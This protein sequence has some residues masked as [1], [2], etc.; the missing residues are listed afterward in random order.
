LFVVVHVLFHNSTHSKIK[1][2]KKK[3]KPK[4]EQKDHKNPSRY[5]HVKYIVYN[6]SFAIDEVG[7]SNMV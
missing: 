2:R 1:E 5:K 6:K 3:T 4:E 7:P